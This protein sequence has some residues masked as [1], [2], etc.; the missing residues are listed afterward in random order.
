MVLYAPPSPRVP[1]V[2]GVRVCHSWAADT[3]LPVC[4][5]VKVPKSGSSDTVFTYGDAGCDG[6]KYE[7]RLFNSDLTK[8]FRNWSLH[9]S[10]LDYKEFLGGGLYHIQVR[11]KGGGEDRRG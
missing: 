4:R 11:G 3:A 8:Q 1:S 6:C 2:R 7:Y 5:L 9:S 10:P